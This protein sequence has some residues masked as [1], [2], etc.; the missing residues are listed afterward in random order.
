M[1]IL[2]KVNFSDV[3]K[4]FDKEHPVNEGSNSWGRIQSSFS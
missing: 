4:I 1:K 3:L 2:K